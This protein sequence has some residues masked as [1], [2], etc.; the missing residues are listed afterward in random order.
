MPIAIA[1]GTALPVFNSVSEKGK[2]T[3][4]LSQAKQIALACKLYAGDNDGKFPPSIDALYPTYLGSRTVLV[5]PFAPGE[6][7][8]YTYHA[9]LTENSPPNTVLLEDAFA[10]GVAGQKVVVHVDNS[11]EVTKTSDE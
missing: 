9:G 10:P 2:A 6:P 1:A 7:E 11:G 8:G 5:S 4:S 3:K